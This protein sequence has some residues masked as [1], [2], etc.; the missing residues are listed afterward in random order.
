MKPL[1]IPEE[2]TK[3][4]SIETSLLDNAHQLLEKGYRYLQRRRYHKAQRRLEQALSI[5]QTQDDPT[6]EKYNTILFHLS[7]ALQHQG[8]FQEAQRYL[9]QVLPMYKLVYGEDH[10][11]VGFI[12]NHIGALAK[13]QGQLEEAMTYFQADAVILKKNIDH[14]YYPS[15]YAAC[16]NNIATVLQDQGH[17]EDA[18]A[19]YLK[20]LRLDESFDRPHLAITLCNLAS[21]FVV[22]HEA[23]D[24]FKEHMISHYDLRQSVDLHADYVRGFATF[25]HA[26]GW[27][28]LASFF[29]K[30][31]LDMRHHGTHD[32]VSV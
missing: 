26:Q 12:L 31:V 8:Q 2:T 1:V 21:L 24:L 4:E 29:Y 32:P 28:D 9:E 17:L 13:D 14:P 18:Y 3:N 11:N 5:Y 7:E 19:Y 6:H 10:I 23:R 27:Y 22:V 16:C 20:A 15:A 25:F 30:Y